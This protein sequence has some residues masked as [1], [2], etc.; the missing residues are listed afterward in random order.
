VQDAFFFVDE[1]F[2]D[3]Y[4]AE[5]LMVPTIIKKRVSQGVLPF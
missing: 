5:K 4:F 3:K 2:F 1:S